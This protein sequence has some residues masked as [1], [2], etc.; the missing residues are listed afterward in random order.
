MALIG[1]DIEQISRVEAAMA[2]TPKF[3]VRLF[4]AAECEYC[5]SKAH[6]AQHFTA[7]FCAKEAFAKAIGQSV[8]WQDVE[9]VNNQTGAPMINAYGEAAR[10][11]NGRKTSVSLSHAGDYAVAMVMIED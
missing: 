4:T 2:R 5:N 8:S 9:I 1:T 11:L 10:V 6:P 7:R 3:T